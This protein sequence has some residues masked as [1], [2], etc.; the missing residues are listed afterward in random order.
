MNTAHE[1][2]DD[3]GSWA[4][5]HPITQRAHRALPRCTGE[6]DQGDRDCSCPTGHVVD[7]LPEDYD[8]PE[9]L[10]V[11]ESVKFWGI[12]MAPGIALLGVVG[13]AIWVRFGHVW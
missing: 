13:F 2:M 3:M 9:P 7:R 4:E 1:G 6:C 10:T 8:K 12:A 11:K 5:S